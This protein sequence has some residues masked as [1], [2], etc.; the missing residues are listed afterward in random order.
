MAYLDRYKANVEIFDLYN[1]KVNEEISLTPVFSSA[2]NQE[3]LAYFANCHDS[4]IKKY[5]PFA[6]I[7]DSV[8][9]KEKIIHLMNMQKLR[10]GVF[11]NIR[12]KSVGLTIGYILMSSPISGNNLNEWSLDYWINKNYR[13]QGIMFECLNQALNILQENNVPVVFATTRSD[14]ETSIRLLKKLGFSLSK[15]RLIAEQYGLRLN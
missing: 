4:E 6:H 12:I 15:S 7:T 11:L 14:N 8:K 2:I 1:Y 13:K 5:L 10:Q 3:A 9:A